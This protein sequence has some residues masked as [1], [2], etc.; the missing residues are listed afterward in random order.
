MLERTRYCDACGDRIEIKYYKFREITWNPFGKDT[1]CWCDICEDC[2]DAIG[3]KVRKQR[4]GE[5]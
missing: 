3:E 1:V 2:L 5:E 4:K